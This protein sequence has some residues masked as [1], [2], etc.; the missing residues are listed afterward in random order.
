MSRSDVRPCKAEKRLTVAGPPTEKRNS[1]KST[2]I[3]NH[4]CTNTSVLIDPTPMPSDI[5][6]V[7]EVGASSA[8]LKSASFFIGAKCAPYNDDYMLCKAENAG[9]DE[10]P[11]LAAGRKVTRCASSVLEGVQATCKEAFEAHWK[12]LDQRNQEFHQCRP[13]EHALNKCVFT[14]MVRIT[15][16]RATLMFRVSRRWYQAHARVTSHGT[17]RALS[18]GHSRK[19][20]GACIFRRRWMHRQMLDDCHS[21]LKYTMH[22][23][24]PIML[25]FSS[26]NRCPMRSLCLRNFSAHFSRHDSSLPLSDLDVKSLTQSEKQRSTRLEYI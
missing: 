18:T 25:A 17:K 20:H 2:T 9:K 1:T 12:C 4:A 23:L 8:P 10:K 11:C 16:W 15:A 19:I 14:K 6:H 3:F 7:D 22:Y 26:A 24:P 13:A 5:P 21:F